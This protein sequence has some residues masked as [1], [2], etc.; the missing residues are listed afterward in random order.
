MK[1]AFRLL[2][3]AGALGAASLSL[4]ACD[5]S[6][7]AA[8]INGHTISV[9]SLTHQLAAFTSNRVFVSQFDSS[10]SPA[11]GGDGSTVGGT[12]GAGTYSTKFVSEVLSA[13]IETQAVHQHVVATGNQPTA[14]EVIAARAVNGYIRAS[15]WNKFPREVKD[16]FVETLAD[17]AALTAAPTDSSSLQTPFS[18]IQPFLFSNICVAE[19]TAFDQAAAQSIISSNHVNGAVVCFNQ[20]DL[21]TQAPAFQ[22]AV[23]KLTTVGDISPAI[24]TSYGY[25]VLQLTRRD[26]PGFSVGVQKVIAAA[27]TPPQAISGIISSAHVKVNPRYGTWANGQVSPPQLTNS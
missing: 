10:N 11:Q 5:A 14:D 12:G 6:P 27:E 25:Q 19:A 1:R 18:D 2:S 20:A 24:K 16:F 21:E 23:R 3:L 17:Q 15:Y 9:N 8:V 4:T 26:S 13:M 22:D 7:Y